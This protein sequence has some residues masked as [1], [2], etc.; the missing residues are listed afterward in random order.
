MQRRAIRVRVFGAALAAALTL[1]GCSSQTPDGA[2]PAKH[3]V[4]KT[5]QQIIKEGRDL[6]D[7]GKK[8]KAIEAF[9]RAIKSDPLCKEAYAYRAAAFNETGKPKQA[10]ADYTKAIELDPN[11]SYLYDQRKLIYRHALKDKAKAEAD[12]QKATA[13]REKQRDQIRTQVDKARSASKK[14]SEKK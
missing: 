1:A 14:K 7:S 9:D 4:S 8:D 3:K 2:K 5:T 13:L 12:D 6:L 11:D 10:V